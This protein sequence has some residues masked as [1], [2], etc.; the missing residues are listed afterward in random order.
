[1]LLSQ[2]LNPLGTILVHVENPRKQNTQRLK[3]HLYHQHSPTN[4]PQEVLTKNVFYR[5]FFFFFPE[6]APPVALLDKDHFLQLM[7]NFSK[8]VLANVLDSK[9]LRDF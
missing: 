9:E 3:G 1:M 6:L 2:S 7:G 4:K 8:L 5:F